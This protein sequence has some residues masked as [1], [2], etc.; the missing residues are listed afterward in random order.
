MV[1]EKNMGQ[2]LQR[3]E[4]PVIVQFDRGGCIVLP[5]GGPTGADA[6][7]SPDGGVRS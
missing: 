3:P 7:G 1:V 5:L 6:S 4:T 2:S